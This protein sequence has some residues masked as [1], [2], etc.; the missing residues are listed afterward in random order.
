MDIKTPGAK[1]IKKQNSH[2]LSNYYHTDYILIV[3]RGK[4][5]IAETSSIKSIK[6]VHKLWITNKDLN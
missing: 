5:L 1:D 3:K 4:C 2:M 6:Q